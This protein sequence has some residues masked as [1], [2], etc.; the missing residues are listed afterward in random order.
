VRQNESMPDT[1]VEPT[2][3]DPSESTI[4]VAV[5]PHHLSKNVLTT[6]GQ[7]SRPAGRTSDCLRSWL[8]ECVRVEQARREM[9]GHWSEP[10][11]YFEPPAWHLPWHRWRDDELSAALACS[12]SWLGMR[13]NSRERSVFDSIHRACVTAACTRLHELHCAIEAAESKRAA[14]FAEAE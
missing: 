9:I 4:L 14:E 12:Y 11:D 1:L 10:S 7:A 13:L 2:A 3:V 5:M 8:A 6:L